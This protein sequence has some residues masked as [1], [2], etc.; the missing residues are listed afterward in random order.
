MGRVRNISCR[1]SEDY[2]LCGEGEE[3]EC[4]SALYVCD[5]VTDCEVWQSS[6]DKRS[7]CKCGCSVL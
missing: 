5:G 4:I 1:G 3:E 7:K 6:K 2:W